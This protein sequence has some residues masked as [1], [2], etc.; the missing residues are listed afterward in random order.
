MAHRIKTLLFTFV[1]ALGLSGSALA[2]VGDVTLDGAVNEADMYRISAAYGSKALSTPSPNWDAG[3]DINADKQ[4]NLADLTLAG[5][6]YGDTFNFQRWRRVS[7]G[8]T[9]STLTNVTGKDAVADSRGHVHVIWSE[10]TTSAYTP[11]Y[12]TQLDAAGNPLVEDL[13]LDSDGINPTLAVDGA[14]NVHIVWEHGDFTANY[15]RYAKLSPEGRWLVRPTRFAKNTCYGTAIATDRYHHPHIVHAQNGRLWYTILDDAGRPLVENVPLNTIVTSAVDALSIAIAVDGADNRH[16][17]WYADTPGAGGDVIYTRLIPGELPSPNQITVTHIESW[18]PHRLFIRTDSQ[19]AAHVLWRNFKGDGPGAIYWRRINPDGS[20]SDERLVTTEAYPEAPLQVTFALDAAD[21]IHL[22]ARDNIV[23]AYAS[24]ARL[25]RD[26]N[27]LRPFRQVIYATTGHPAMAVGPTGQAAIFHAYGGTSCTPP[28]P[29]WVRSSVPDAA[30]NDPTRADL[31]VDAAHLTASPRFA[32][33]I[34]TATVTATVTNGGWVTATNVLVQLTDTISHTP[35][36]PVTIAS[37]PPFSSTTVV[38]TFPIPDLEE[39][40]LLPVRV[41]VSSTTPETTLSNNAVT[42]TFGII[43]PVR[44]ADIA[45]AALDET[46]APANRELAAYLIGGQLSARALAPVA[47]T[48]LLTS[49]HAYNYLLGIP[50]NTNAPPAMQTT[51]MLTLTAPGYS[52]ATQV[53][54]LTRDTA[55]PYRVIVNPPEI[56]LYVNQW[57]TLQGTVLSGTLPL[58]QATVTLDGKTQVTTG[59]DGAFRFTKVVSGSHTV[60]AIHAGHAPT[61]AVMQVTTGASTTRALTMLPT[62]KGWV[63]GTVWN[64]WGQPFSGATVQLWGGSTLIA[65]TT[66]DNSGRY[67]LEVANVNAHPSYEIRATASG[68]KPY[69]SGTFALTAGIPRQH[70]FTL[71]WAVTAARLQKSGEVTSWQ[72]QESWNKPDYSGSPIGWFLEQ[73]VQ[74]IQDELE[75]YAYEVDVWWAKYTYALGLNYSEAGGVKTVEGLSVQLKNGA[76]Y[77]YNVQGGQYEA[78]MSD[79]ARTN[80]R[81]D[82]VDLVNVD[83]VGNVTG[84]PYWSSRVVWYANQPD[85]S[86]TVRLYPIGASVPTWSSAALRLCLRVGKYD[87]SR[88][89]TAYWA[90][91]MPPVAVA[92]LNGSGAA[93]GADFQCLLWRLGANEVEVL[94]SAA[95]YAAAVGAG[96]TT[97][98][99]AAP[100]NATVSAVSPQAGVI[101]SLT[102]PVAPPAYIG[103]PF[104]VDVS[105]SGATARPVYGVEFDLRFNPAHLRVQRVE[106]APD[107]RGTYGTWTVLTPALALINAS[108]RLTNTAVV[109]LGALSGLT[110]GNL[111][112]I[113]FTPRISVTTTSLD[114]SDVWLA[115]GHGKL[116]RPD[117][118]LDTS[119]RIVN[120]RLFLPMVVRGR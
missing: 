11:L 79:I 83:S 18:N 30:A 70:D 78:G 39:T 45:V 90:P 74:E 73:T 60:E 50:L 36:A 116:Y 40:S 98:G 53:V 110:Q 64:D 85:G 104:A 88:P 15:C 16:I 76:L 87:A 33:I 65:T 32:R 37:L 20:L 66:T 62:T 61:S 82:Y 114:L 108:G 28:C 94:K 5:R 49:T 77:S 105:L 19:N 22:I 80:V 14:N 8:R 21:R 99:D 25:D 109:R 119:F 86:A 56:K 103:A 75:L 101:V 7:N 72:Q 102:L 57:G 59:A 41:S 4:V 92:S 106:G 23:P 58:A 12:Y 100:P 97:A 17:L 38:R 107:F 31:V 112:R 118:T 96:T 89:D 54:T 48:A 93:A 35:I 34:D 2:L 68:C 27:V 115:D 63:R 10:Y 51:L 6:D 43:P 29:L 26:G 55:N 91:W 117:T 71:E 13:Y 46:Y 69:N 24:Y 113:T 52:V 47:Y 67:A 81:V 120:A 84:G 44:H 111:V 42:T 95:Y 9:T 3:A 1:L